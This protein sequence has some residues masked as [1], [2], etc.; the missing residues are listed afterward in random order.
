MLCFLKLL[1]LSAL[2]LSNVVDKA[3]YAGLEEFSMS[4][5]VQRHITACSSLSTWTPE[6]WSC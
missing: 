2:S 1:A 5:T 4:W 6:G 3:V